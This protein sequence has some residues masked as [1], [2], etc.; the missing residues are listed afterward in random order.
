MRIV[1]AEPTPA[2]SESS[3][4]LQGDPFES[5]TVANGELTVPEGLGIG[6]TGRTGAAF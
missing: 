3:S 5:P 2:K 4:G 6:I 1:R